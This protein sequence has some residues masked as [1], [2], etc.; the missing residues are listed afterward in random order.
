MA[1]DTGDDNWSAGQQHLRDQ[2][3]LAEVGL[4]EEVCSTTNQ[5][6]SRRSSA[7]IPTA[8]KARTLEPDNIHPSHHDPLKNMNSQF[9]SQR[10]IF[11]TA[12]SDHSNVMT[13]NKWFREPCRQHASGTR[14][15]PSLKA[16]A[17]DEPKKNGATT[18]YDATSAAADGTSASAVSRFKGSRMMKRGVH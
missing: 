2:V 16:S 9:N 4:Q 6:Q 1:Q 17:A 13:E 5:S 10:F 18:T 8:R 11:P 12:R 14:E 7:K 3:Q 15:H